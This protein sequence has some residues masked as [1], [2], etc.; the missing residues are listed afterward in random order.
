MCDIEALMALANRNSFSKMWRR[1]VWL[2][3]NDVSEDRT[4][5]MFMVE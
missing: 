4:P 5:S 1:V 2:K 3:F